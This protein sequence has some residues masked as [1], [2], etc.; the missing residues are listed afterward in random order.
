MKKVK[1]RVDYTITFNNTSSNP[2]I[3]QSS[4]RG[5]I[6]STSSQSFSSSTVLTSNQ[7]KPSTALK[8]MKDNFMTQLEEKLNA[9]GHMQE[10]YY[11]YYYYC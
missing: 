10:V 5:L 3:V 4:S 11:Y 2:S 8:Q 9:F 1:L 7:A 6:S